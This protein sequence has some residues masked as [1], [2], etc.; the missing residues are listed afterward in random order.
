[1]PI[2]KPFM[3]KKNIYEIDY[4]KLKDM[5]VKCLIFDLDNTL[6]L[7]SHKECPKE[8]KELIKKLKKEDKLIIITSHIKEDILDLADEVYRFDSGVL[9]KNE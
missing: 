4:K 3:Y 1:M 8:T 2:F 7:I 9:T 6:G 5:G